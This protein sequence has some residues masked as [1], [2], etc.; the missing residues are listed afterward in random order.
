MTASKMELI[1][2]SANPFEHLRD[3]D[4]LI[5]HQEELDAL[6]ENKQRELASKLLMSC[7]DKKLNTYGHAISAIRPHDESDGCFYHVLNRAYRTKSIIKALH[8][9]PKPQDFLLGKDFDLSLFHEFG[10]LSLDSLKGKEIEIAKKLALIDSEDERNALAVKAENA[11]PG[12]PFASQLR[13]AFALRRDI[14]RLLKSDAPY[15]FFLSP[16]FDAELCKQFTSLFNSIVPEAI[17]EKM[18]ATPEVK[19]ERVLE[20]IG[21]AFPDTVLFDSTRI[22]FSKPV[23]SVAPIESTFKTPNA[24]E[25]K[26]PGSNSSL[27]FI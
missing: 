16:E 21:A 10:A 11:F 3:A 1:K 6:E 22:L 20:R 14:D 4:A 9:A 15:N 19:R 18:A 23:K 26:D 12:S 2:T 17:A 13:A 8:Q 24:E 27:S 5:E 25:P 7:P